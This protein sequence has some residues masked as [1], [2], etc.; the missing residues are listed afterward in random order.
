MNGIP[1][2]PVEIVRGKA[3]PMEF[4][5]DLMNAISE[6]KGCYM[7]QELVT[8]T[9]HRGVVRKRILPVQL[10]EWDQSVDTFSPDPTKTFAGVE[11]E[12]DLMPVEPTDAT[13]FLDVTAI[14]SERSFGRIIRVFGNIGLA[15]VRLDTMTPG[16]LFALHRPTPSLGQPT[17]ILG[18]ACIPSWWPTTVTDR[19]SSQ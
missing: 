7:G 1:E 8:R 3:I 11:P 5:I 17:F 19:G 16:G 18:R 9:L 4:N 14:Q 10:F 15:L 13:K 12:A 2:G 6:R